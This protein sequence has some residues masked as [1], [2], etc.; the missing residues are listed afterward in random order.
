MDIN[1]IHEQIIKFF[2]ENPNPPDDKVHALGEK[3]GLDPDV[4]EE[5]IYM[6][7][8]N[9]I[10]A[11]KSKGF[12]GKYD[13]KQIAMGK[14]V[15]KEH[16][17][18]PMIAEKIAKD[19]LAEIPDYYTRLA[20]MES[21]VGIVHEIESK[22]KKGNG[23]DINIESETLQ[24][25]NFRKVLYT[26][27]NMQLVVMS[28]KD[29]IGVETH[30][31]GDQF[32]R[33]EDGKGKAIIGGR[34]F[35]IESKTAFI[36]PEG[37]EHNVINTG[38]KDLKLYS[39]YAPPHHPPGTIHKT[40]EAAEMSE[41]TSLKEMSKCKEGYNWC[42]MKEKCVPA[43][44]E[45]MKKAMTEAGFEKNP[46]GWSQ[47]SLQKYM[48]TFSSK[49]KGGVKAEGF[50][51]KCVNKV[52][53]R[54]KNPEGFCA[55]LK[56]ESYGSTGWR[57]KDKSPKEVSK[58]VKKAKFK[59]ESDQAINQY[60]DFISEDRD[61]IFDEHA[62]LPN[63]LINILEYDERPNWIG[64]CVREYEGNPGTQVKCLQAV[65]EYAAANP[66]YQYRI[67]RYIDVIL[68]RRGNQDDLPYP[69]PN[70]DSREINLGT[71]GSYERGYTNND[72]D[73]P[74]IVETG[75]ADNVPS[76][77][78]ADETDETQ[79]Y[80]TQDDSEDDSKFSIDFD[81]ELDE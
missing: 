44:Q 61:A 68:G 57:G 52:K 2:T 22:I 78:L 17:T 72:Q 5:H 41:N 4:F 12:T 80:K 71:S 8:S 76:G 10:T 54:L 13:P 39:V 11:G 70:P 6:I 25:T 75:M 20:K 74:G 34:E 3:L 60:L 69:Q 9:I 59:V 49:M 62:P 23:F 56:D 46:K 15:E 67:D 16:T 45:K 38:N 37:K 77:G 51:D 73:Q 66:F 28:V 21:G 48:R 30:D 35:P 65:R 53:G 64:Y 29:D 42:P 63:E 19:H 7:L 24:N 55:A 81:E 18:E 40:K 50:F 58:D 1:K 26:A 47:K 43:G 36:I 79:S 27:P 31:D 32:I 14:N 33:I